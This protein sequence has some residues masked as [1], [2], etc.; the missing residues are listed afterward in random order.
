M[1][2]ETCRSAAPL[3]TSAPRPVQD[4]KASIEFTEGEAY[5]K[6]LI[7]DEYE[8]DFKGG[9]QKLRVKLVQ[10]QGGAKVRPYTS[11]GPFATPQSVPS[12]P[13]M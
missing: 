11:A 4:R 5:D 2:D 8:S 3:L 7:S 9:M 6:G 10:L 1:L 12:P 13:C